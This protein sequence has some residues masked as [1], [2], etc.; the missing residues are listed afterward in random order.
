MR[1]FQ[2][3]WGQRYPG[4]GKSW[5]ED[6]SNLTSFLKY[7]QEI[8]AYI[9]TTNHLERFMKEVRRRAKVIEIFP[10]EDAASKILY[11]VSKEMNE[12]YSRKVLRYFE[13]VKEK[14]LEIRRMRYG[15][16]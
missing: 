7:P 9:Y 4:I 5:L 16:G 13:A 11:I 10:Q 2:R 3:E 12:R 8:R 15:Y 6:I 1:R 14:L